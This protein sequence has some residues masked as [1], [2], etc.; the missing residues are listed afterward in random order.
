MRAM[1]KKKVNDNYF[2]VID[3]EKKAYILGFLIADGCILYETKPS[4]HVSKSIRFSNTIDDKEAIYCIRDEICPEKTLKE[5][6]T[7]SNRRKKPQYSFKWVSNYM[8]DILENKYKIKQRKTYDKEFE[9]PQGSISNDLFRHFIRG[10]F[11]GDGHVDYTGIQFV[12]TSEKF[13]N[14]ILHWFKNFNYKVLH[15]DGKTTDYWTTIIYLDKKEKECIR[16]FLYDGASVF[17]SRKKLIF[18]TEIS[19]SSRNGIIDIV[20]HRAEKI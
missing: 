18:D 5:Y 15:I 17:L 20:E 16:H 12:F 4:G 13:M 19:Y 6:K 3:T 8:V 11:D 10:L 7:A 2:D 9:L 14:Q 1:Y